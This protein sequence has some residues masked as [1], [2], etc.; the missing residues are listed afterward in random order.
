[1]YLFALI[2]LASSSTFY[3]TSSILGAPDIDTRELR[4]LE[5]GEIIN[6]EQ[7]ESRKGQTF[8][9]VAIFNASMERTSQTIQD[10]TSYPAFMPNVEKIDIIKNDGRNA[11]I[12]YHLGLPLGKKKRYRLALQSEDTSTYTIIQWQMQD[13]P[14]IP[15]EE[16]IGNTTGFWLLKPYKENRTLVRYHVYTD[17]GDVPFG[18]GW[19]VDFMS[20][21]SIPK[22]L[23][24]TRDYIANNQ[25]QK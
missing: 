11:I 2:L 8:E 15:G 4:E 25:E 18:L 5:R 9:A 16:R 20:E 12:N 19:I 17:P 21:K 13:W 6:R 7:P 10:Y 3:S 14:E 22:V 1:M 23:K 24:N